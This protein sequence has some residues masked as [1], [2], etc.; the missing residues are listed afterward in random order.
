MTDEETRQRDA[1]ERDWSFLGHLG[2]YAYRRG[3]LLKLAALERT[4]LEK[5]EKLE[6]LRALEHGYV[7]RVGLTGSERFGIDTADDLA[8]FRRKLGLEGT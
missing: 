6:Q 8:R 5:R 4:E 7:I 1:D 2:I 3:F